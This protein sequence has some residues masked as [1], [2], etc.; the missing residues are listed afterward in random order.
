[1]EFQIIKRA[2][3]FDR[4][5]MLTSPINEPIPS[6]LHQES[7]KM[8]TIGKAPSCLAK[9]VQDIGPDRLNNISGI[10]LGA[11]RTIQL[12]TDCDPEIRLIGQKRFLRGYEV[13]II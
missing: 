8:S 12:P 4:A 13:A 7:A 2:F 11:Q 9:T 10:Q 5:M 3:L 6:H 1:M